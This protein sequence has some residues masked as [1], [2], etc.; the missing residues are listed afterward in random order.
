M[1]QSR[2]LRLV[3]L[4]GPIS[5]GS[6]SRIL[7]ICRALPDEI[8][9]LEE[10]AGA[11]YRKLLK[12]V[13]RDPAESWDS[14]YDLPPPY[15]LDKGSNLPSDKWGVQILRV[16]A[17]VLVA[18][19]Y[20]CL[21]DV[22]QQTAF[23]RMV[24]TLFA[25]GEEQEARRDRSWQNDLALAFDGR[26]IAITV[27]PQPN[28]G[29]V[30]APQAAFICPVSGPLAIGGGIAQYVYSALLVA[31]RTMEE[32]ENDWETHF[33]VDLFR[34]FETMPDLAADPDKD[35]CWGILG[36]TL[37]EELAGAVLLNRGALPD[38][39]LQE[40]LGRLTYIRNKFLLLP[41]GSNDV[42]CS[43]S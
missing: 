38:E 43:I 15:F 18:G 42:G 12:V 25:V 20:C 8:D 17:H 29:L 5:T 37:T 39:V 10:A 7:F 27:G 32:H 2:E 33:R 19:L 9:F 24:Q 1:P 16:E 36:T 14:C 22:T 3:P 21:T 40:V 30:Q 11:I 31:L 26:N 4:F 28:I 13:G 23:E 35:C 34:H 6:E 41:A